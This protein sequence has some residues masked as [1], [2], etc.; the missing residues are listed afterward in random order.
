M[1]IRELVYALLAG[2]LLTARQ[3]VADAHRAR[4]NWSDLAKPDGLTNREM[5]VAAG[6]VELLA[7]RAGALSP[8]W[9]KNVGPV[10]ELLVLDPGLEEM[11]RTFARAQT[12]GPKPLRSRNMVAPP[13]FLDVA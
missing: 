2:D 11:P 9:T 6:M 13:D 3:C 1:D 7:S 12:A 4:V 10:D 5:S 8:T